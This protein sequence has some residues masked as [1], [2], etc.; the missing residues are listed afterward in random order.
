M[1]LFMWCIA[2]YARVSP[3]HVFRNVTL[4]VGSFRLEL[5]LPV[6]PNTV[7][8]SNAGHGQDTA[9]GL[10][11]GHAMRKDYTPPR[12]TI[13]D[14]V[15]A[16]SLWSSVAGASFLAA[17]S[18]TLDID[19]HSGFFVM[20]DHVR[21][22]CDELVIESGMDAELMELS[23]TMHQ[24]GARKTVTVSDNAGFTDGLDD[25]SDFVKEPT[26][27]HASAGENFAPPPDQVALN[28]TL[29]GTASVEIIFKAVNVS[30]HAQ[31]SVVVN[32]LPV[33]TTFY[34]T[35]LSGFEERGVH[36][37]SLERS[38]FLAI[39]PFSFLFSAVPRHV[40][41]GKHMRGRMVTRLSGTCNSSFQPGT[42]L[43]FGKI[44]AWPFLGKPFFETRQYCS[45]VLHTLFP[46][47][48]R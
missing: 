1:L 18:G 3:V 23:D 43:Y 29:C 10:P 24:T 25:V 45:G 20:H 31:L 15:T 32:L 34:S 39:R 7:D 48:C 5:L 14:T 2:S 41:K 9:Q 33:S 40:R 37:A 22:Y 16:R 17:S 8:P 27:E 12:L 21:D 6:E 44:P 13:W 47:M 4:S 36:D 46:R 26:F 28:G 11:Q 35:V 30:G 38:Y 19:Q 42:F